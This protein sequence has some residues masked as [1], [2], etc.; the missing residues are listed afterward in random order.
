MRN[1]RRAQ[2]D[3][4]DFPIKEAEAYL[5]WKGWKRSEFAD[6]SPADSLY[7]TAELKDINPVCAGQR[8]LEL[9]FGNGNFLSYCRARGAKVVGIEIDPELVSRAT[10]AGFEVFLSSDTLLDDISGS[11]FDAI[12]AFDVFEHIELTALQTLLGQLA[13]LLSKDGFIMARFPSGDSPF[14]G[15]MYNGDRTHRSLIGSGIMQQLSLDAGLQVSRMEG[16]RLPVFG[17]GAKTAMRRLPVIALRK[18]ISSVMRRVYYANAPRVID[19]NAVAVL[20]RANQLT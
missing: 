1:S 3:Q 15:A 19:P 8:I 16:A 14:S 7:F 9:G 20:R 11:P 10:D 17:L 2:L 4:G 12:C 5:E 13:T 18:I 6:C